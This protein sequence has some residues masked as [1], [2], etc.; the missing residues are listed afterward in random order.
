MSETL[1]AQASQAV[2]AQERGSFERSND[3]FRAFSTTG[4]YLRARIH[5]SVVDRLRRESANYRLISA[6]LAMVGRVALLLIL[7]GLV[8]AML[9]LTLLSYRLTRPLA[10]LAEAAQR[11]SRGD[12]SREIPIRDWDE[13]GYVAEAFNQMSRGLTRHIQDLQEKSALEVRLRERELENLAMQNVLQE[14]RLQALQGQMNP[15]F[16][17]NTLNAGVHLANLERADRTAAFFE[18]VGRLFRYNLRHPGLAVE[19]GRAH[20]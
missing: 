19:I 1:L 13:V 9:V 16:L 15:H 2:E 12:F 14:T 10:E 18:N 6:R 20:V 8:L 5:Q 3:L 7:G 17:F 11:A 4:E